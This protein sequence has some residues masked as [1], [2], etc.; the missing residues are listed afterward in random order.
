MTGCC[1]LS[2]RVSVV[3][4]ASGLILSGVL[5]GV[6]IVA[7]MLCVVNRKRMLVVAGTVVR[8]HALLCAALGNEVI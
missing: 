7:S 8:C 2:E 1:A 3:G 5:Q 4:L 6:N